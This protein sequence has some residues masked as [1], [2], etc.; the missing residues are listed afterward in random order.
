MKYTKLNATHCVM[1]YGDNSIYNRS[2]AILYEK[3]TDS[4]GRPRPLSDDELHQVFKKEKEVT[5]PTIL[6]PYVLWYEP[7]AS[8]VWYQPPCTKDITIKGKV[9]KYSHPGLVFRVA[10]QGL[11]VAVYS[12]KENFRPTMD[13]QLYASPYGGTDVHLVNVGMCRVNQLKGEYALAKD[14]WMEWSNIF[15]ESGFNRQPIRRDRLK[16]INLTMER[17]LQG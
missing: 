3:D 12:K 7:K 1:I 17:F 4:W 11:S 9:K 5:P 6:D 16:K 14:A 15:Y 8:L 10:G 2:S 13:A